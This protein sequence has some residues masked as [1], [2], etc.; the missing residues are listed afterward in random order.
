MAQ[1][2]IDAVRALL[3]AKPRP[4]GWAERRQ[5]LD[6]VGSVW[7]VA[8]DVQLTPTDLGGLPGAG[9]LSGQPGGPVAYNAASLGRRPRSTG[10]PP[11]ARS[12]ARA[13]S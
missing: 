12:K 10:A 4:T 5:R 2:E 11:G 1:S 13:P 3:T 8:G 6:E 7:P 9:G